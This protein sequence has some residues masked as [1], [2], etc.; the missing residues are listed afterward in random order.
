MVQKAKLMP[1]QADQVDSVYN[2]PN[3]TIHNTVAPVPM[4]PELNKK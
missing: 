4:L 1:S 2:Q 3:T